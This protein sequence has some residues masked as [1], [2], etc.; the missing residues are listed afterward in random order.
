MHHQ[1]H[2]PTSLNALLSLL[3]S[4][5]DILNDETV[6][7]TLRTSTHIIKIKTQ[8]KKKMTQPNMYKYNLSRHTGNETN[9]VTGVDDRQ[10][11]GLLHGTRPSSFTTVL[12]TMY[13][14]V[15]VRSRE[16]ENISYVTLAMRAFSLFVMLTRTA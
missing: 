2:Q 15:F 7:P 5:N 13:R 14:R 8:S 12:K 11:F 10:H 4:S 6:C 3:I 1:E 16:K 9:L